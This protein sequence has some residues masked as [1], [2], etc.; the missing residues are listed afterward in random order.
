MQKVWTYGGLLG[1]VTTILTLFAG[2]ETIA[3]SV[4]LKPVTIYIVQRVKFEP[5]TWGFNR[6]AITIPPRTTVTWRSVARNSDSHTSTSKDNVWSSPL[7]NPG[8]AWSFT[9]SQ[10]GHY[11]YQCSLHP[12]MVGVIN[13]VA[14][15]PA[16]SAVPEPPVTVAGAMSARLR[17]PILLPMS[18]R[19]EEHLFGV[20]RD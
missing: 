8:D 7:L 11:R 17:S 10:V 19:V 4:A 5:P 1:L 12:W 14:G 3:A 2:A 13:V 18:E 16:P 20:F 15:A 6:M 9:F